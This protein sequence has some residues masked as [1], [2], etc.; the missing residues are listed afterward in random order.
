[1]AIQ[2]QGPFCKTK[3]GYILITVQ[4]HVHQI[5]EWL[6]SASITGITIIEDLITS[7]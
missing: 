7:N 1:M 2:I 4:Y 5:C 6:T 3:P